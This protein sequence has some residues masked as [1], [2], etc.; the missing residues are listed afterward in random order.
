[1]VRR[2]PLSYRLLLTSLSLAA[3]IFLQPAANAQTQLANISSRGFV[4]TGDDVMIGGFIIGGTEAKRI[5]I[6]AKGPSLT[7]QGVPDVLP[8]PNVTIFDAAGTAIAFSENAGEHPSAGELTAAGLAPTNGAEAGLVVSLPPGAYTAVVRGGGTGN[9]LIEIFD[10]E[11]DSGKD[12]ELLNLSTRNPVLQGDNV[13]IGGF[14]ITGVGTQQVAI[15][16]V[17]GSLN[18][19]GVPGA[20]ADPVLEIYDATQTQLSANDNW[21]SGELPLLTM[22]GLELE[23]SLESG[24]VLSLPP[25][26]YTAVIRGQ[27]GTTGNALVEIFKLADRA[28][29]FTTVFQSKD[30]ESF[31]SFVFN[32]PRGVMVSVLNSR[33]YNETAQGGDWSEQLDWSVKSNL[34]GSLMVL[35]RKTSGEGSTTLGWGFME[36]TVAA[37]NTKIRLRPTFPPAATTDQ[38]LRGE[39][40]AADG[41]VSPFEAF[42][43]PTLFSA[44]LL[45]PPWTFN[46]PPDQVAAAGA[47][48]LAFIAQVARQVDFVLSNQPGLFPPQSARAITTGA[49]RP[50]V[51]DPNEATDQLI[52]FTLEAVDNGAEL[53]SDFGKGT[54]Y[55]MPLE[56]LETT[57]KTI[58]FSIQTFTKL[59]PGASFDDLRDIHQDADAL[60]DNVRELVDRQSDINDGVAM[61]DGA[62]QRYIDKLI[63]S[64]ELEDQMDDDGVVTEQERQSACLIYAN[65]R[66]NV[67]EMLLALADPTLDAA[68][69]QNLQ[70]IYDSLMIQDTFASEHNIL[71]EFK[72]KNEEQAAANAR[73]FGFIELAERHEENLA[74]YKEL[75]S[76][77]ERH[78]AF[79]GFFFRS[80]DSDRP[81]PLPGE[82]EEDT[83]ERIFST[84]P[85]MGSW[86]NSDGTTGRAPGLL[87]P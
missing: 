13:L 80:T 67:E 44:S 42:I 10:L 26:A 62:R 4:G 64:Q 79:L 73:T 5:A 25:G 21:G 82:L 76:C 30:P 85:I 23:D 17:G 32:D 28:L 70:A 37:T 69:R 2:L 43:P 18:A 81:A 66:T 7:D 22:A 27:S 83:Q 1:M 33:T 40:V 31:A 78:M 45:P 48:H 6:L 38:R 15:R 58:T 57:I 84:Q 11:F 53:L 34:D 36:I 71:T 47:L 39:T 29:E 86:I 20:L 55:D 56:Y 24:A 14:I 46:T 87:L 59:K 74:Q 3:T 49:S 9:A 77:L 63:E 50:I 51:G 8:D 75:K 65:M 68:T 12:A 52:D 41:T 35:G 19:R 72:I 60:N 61:F 54:K 16:A